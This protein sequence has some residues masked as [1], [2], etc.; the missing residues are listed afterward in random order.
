MEDRAP[1]IELDCVRGGDPE[2]RVQLVLFG[3]S[4]SATTQFRGLMASYRRS[5]IAAW[6]FIDVVRTL[7]FGVASRA[8]RLACP[9]TVNPTTGEVDHDTPSRLVSVSLIFERLDKASSRRWVYVCSSA[10]GVNEVPR[11]R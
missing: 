4:R 2:H 11:R 3:G 6:D 10:T 5:A 7:P 9:H 1:A 8:H